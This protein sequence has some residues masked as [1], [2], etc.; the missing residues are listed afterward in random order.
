[1]SS[2]CETNSEPSLVSSHRREMAELKIAIRNAAMNISITLM[3][4]AITMA[5]GCGSRGIVARVDADAISE[6]EFEL[7]LLRRAGKQV[8]RELITQRL[9]RREADRRGISLS[10]QELEME[11]KRRLESRQLATLSRDRLDELK[12]DVELSLLLKKLCESDPDAMPSTNEI[13]SY[14]KAHKE[15]FAIPER[16][17]LRCIILENMASAISVYRA[18]RHE[19]SS[20]SKLAF[21]LSVDKATKEKGG[22]MGIIPI[23]NLSPKLR[24]I[25]KGMKVGDV[26]EP[27]ELD[28]RWWIVKL[29]E[30]FP[31]EQRPIEDVRQLIAQILRE[32]KAKAIQA[33]Y[34]RKLWERANV[35]IYRRELIGAMP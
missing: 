30:Y 29:E 9:I 10:Q 11:L 4:A 16:V 32:Q 3:L 34:I 17:R 6:R 33:N 13:I 15:E 35:K 7:E 2:I 20:F 5:I 22:D 24:S 8:L 25:V 27:F 26:S 23:H 1:M 18:L 14:Y 31:R 12:R 19:G 28:G 21:E